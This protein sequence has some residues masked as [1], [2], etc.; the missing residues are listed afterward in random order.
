MSSPDEILIARLGCE[1]FIKGNKKV[2]NKT[3]VERRAPVAPDGA[4]SGDHF[5]LHYPLSR[6]LCPPP[7]LTMACANNFAEYYF[8]FLSHF[9]KKN[10]LTKLTF[11]APFEEQMRAANEAYRSNKS[12]SRKVKNRP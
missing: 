3:D 5:C 6:M 1:G 10:I 8:P 11:E 9:Q 2:C 12:E 7:Q 4:I